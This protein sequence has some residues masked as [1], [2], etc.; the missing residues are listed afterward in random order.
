LGA[1]FNP[2]LTGVDNIYFYGAL[3]GVGREEM[4]RRIDE[5]LAFADIGEFVYQPVKTYSSGMYVRLAFAVIVNM[6]ADVLIVDEALAVGDAFFV[7]KCMRFLRRFIQR[8]TLIFVSHDAAMI[9]NL[10]SRAIWLDGGVVRADGLP[11]AVSEAYLE[12]LFEDQ[13][14]D[15]ASPVRVPG[16][17]PQADD[18]A[19]DMRQAFINRTPYR[20][21]IELFDFCP[22][23]A[24]FGKGNATIVAVQLFNHDDK[25]LAW[26]VG[27]ESVQLHIRCT[28]LTSIHGPIVGFYVKDRFGQ[29][30]FGDNTFNFSRFT[31]LDVQ[32]GQHFAA[33]FWF[34]MPILPVGDYS[35]TAAIA[36][37][38]QQE[39]VQHHWMHDA[40]IFKSHSS[41][42]STGLMGV[43]MKQIDLYTL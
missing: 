21:D 11:K 27:G 39:H 25:P 13:Q 43:P 40:L 4:H 29:Y 28:A 24:Q 35:I 10:C 32:P 9:C 16:R 2:E 20:N 5:I 38:T 12:T 6:D 37:G 23:A 42:V 30:I 19:V 15:S 33:T 34:R 31:P 18:D 14:G 41:S 3:L 8:G 36:E 22:D 1:G 7:Q 17:I 26:I